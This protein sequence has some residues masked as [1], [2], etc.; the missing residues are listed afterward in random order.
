MLS[1]VLEAPLG[2]VDTPPLR[3]DP[4]V[5]DLLLAAVV[6]VAIP[7]MGGRD[8]GWDAPLPRLG[9]WFFS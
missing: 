6:P 4:A 5:V 7:W 2:V 9:R 1:P 8:R 3:I